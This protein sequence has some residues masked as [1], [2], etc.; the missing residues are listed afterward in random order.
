MNSYLLVEESLV[1]GCLDVD[2][3]VALA[4]VLQKFYIFNFKRRSD[5]RV[6]INQLDITNDFSPAA[7]GVHRP[8]VLCKQF[9]DHQPNLIT[10]F[11]PIFGR[12]R[13]RGGCFYSILMMVIAEFIENRCCYVEDCTGDHSLFLSLSI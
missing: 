11:F 5:E 6:I 4:W 7:D 3:W 8:E 1:D 12:H 13:R 2:K 9:D 10:L